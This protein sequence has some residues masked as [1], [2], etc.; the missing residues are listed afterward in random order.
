MVD[1]GSGWWIL[2]QDG[3]LGSG[4]WI[5]GLDGGSG[6]RMGSGVRVEV[7]GGGWGP[8]HQ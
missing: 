3:G 5:W 6:V 4:W 2:G 1:L 8:A 7:W